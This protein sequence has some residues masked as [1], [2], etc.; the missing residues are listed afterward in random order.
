[1]SLF[2]A[3]LPLG[4]SPSGKAVASPMP[5]TSDASAVALC[6]TRS[7]IVVAFA[8]RP[9]RLPSGQVEVDDYGSLGLAGRFEDLLPFE[10]PQRELRTLLPQ[11]VVPFQGEQVRI[12]LG[13]LDVLE[14]RAPGAPRSTPSTALEPAAQGRMI[15]A[16]GRCRGTTGA[17]GCQDLQD[18]PA[19]RLGE[20]ATRRQTGQSLLVRIA[21]RAS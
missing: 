18:P 14:E 15:D 16:G 5:V 8:R 13:P 12:P 17:T 4:C 20:L 3:P 9:R 1:M 10:E 6:R 19:P 11:G 7:V 21:A 2:V